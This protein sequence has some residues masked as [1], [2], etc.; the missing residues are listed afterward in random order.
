MYLHRIDELEKYKNTAS[1]VHPNLQNSR[2]TS[3]PKAEPVARVIMALPQSVYLIPKQ[4]LSFSK[5]T[6]LLVCRTIE[7]QPVLLS[8]G[9][10]VSIEEAFLVS[11]RF[12]CDDAKHGGEY[13]YRFLIRNIEGNRAL[14]DDGESVK[15]V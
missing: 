6:T 7:G 9:Y 10:I 8:K 1:A 2:W 11:R 15:G 14:F 3:K 5:H 13:E 12:R 4:E